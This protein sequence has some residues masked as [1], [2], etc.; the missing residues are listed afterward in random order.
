V[1]EPAY[2][3]GNFISFSYPFSSPMIAAVRLSIQRTD[4]LSC[5]SLGSYV[6]L[7]QLADRHRRGPRSDDKM[8]N[9]YW[10]KL[11]AS[12]FPPLSSSSAIS[13]R[14]AFEIGSDEPL[15]IEACSI[16]CLSVTVGLTLS[17][18]TGVPWVDR[19]SPRLA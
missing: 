10:L 8:V 3:Q 1:V 19:P 4:S 16:V 15:G 2:F 11:N 14:Q 5:C 12:L 6:A 17:Y 7:D 9:G 18:I 13:A